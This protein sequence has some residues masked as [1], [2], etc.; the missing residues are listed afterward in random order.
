M[1][2]DRIDRK[3]LNLLQA[4]FP[5]TGKPYASLGDDLDIAEDEVI[6]RVGRLKTEGFIRLIG[7]LLDTSKLDYKTTLVAMRVTETELDKATQIIINHS[8]VS[9]AYERNHHFNLWFTLALPS[10]LDIDTTLKE[11][12]SS[13]MSE[14]FFDITALNLFKLRTYLSLD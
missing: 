7:P 13:I 11:M 5:I 14:A 10:S 3:L 6:Q 2:L 1:H 12:F 8:G 9:H 4:E